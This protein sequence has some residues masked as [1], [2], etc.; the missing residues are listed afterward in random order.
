MTKKKT[1]TSS[2]DDD[3]VEPN[4]CI[5]L[6]D[7]E[8]EVIARRLADKPWSDRARF[9]NN[10][11]TES[12]ENLTKHLDLIGPKIGKRKVDAYV[13][14][15]L[16]GIHGRICEVLDIWGLEAPPDKDAAQVFALSG[17]P[18]HREAARVFCGTSE[19]ALN[20]LFEPGSGLMVFK[21][22]S[23]CMRPGLNELWREHIKGEKWNGA[24]E[25][26][27]VVT[28]FA[29]WGALEDEIIAFGKAHPEYDDPDV[30][31]QRDKLI[32]RLCA[33]EDQITETATTSVGGMAVKLR[34]LAYM[35][36]PM[37]GLQDL[38]ATPAKDTDFG[39]FVAG[40]RDDGGLFLDDK[41]LIDTLRDAERLA[42]AS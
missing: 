39:G 25:P 4:T 1:D 35:K 32:E 16:I 28:L 9:F 3:V 13:D 24:A 23:L 33:V 22:M 29:E 6:I 10:V 30:E 2:E 14:I 27:A 8:A 38:Y 15:V 36:F 7:M 12:L 42:G 41:L 19:A 20:R 17:S 11:I 5:L 26:D 37:K 40:R 18:E 21:N 31:K 34:L